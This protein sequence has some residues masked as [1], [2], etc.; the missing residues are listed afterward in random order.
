MMN[1]LDVQLLFRDALVGEQLVVDA[2]LLWNADENS[3][4]MRLLLGDAGG[5]W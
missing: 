3:G 4:Q 2:V 1:F 5:N